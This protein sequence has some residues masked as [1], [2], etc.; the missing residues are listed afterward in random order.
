[1]WNYV[2]VTLERPSA[3][4]TSF[5]HVWR[6]TGPQAPG[7]LS[8][9]CG[10]DSGGGKSS[11]Y[12]WHAQEIRVSQCSLS[13]KLVCVIVQVCEEEAEGE[14]ICDTKLHLSEFF[15][16][17]GRE[18]QY[19]L[20]SSEKSCWSLGYVSFCSSDPLGDRNYA[21][22]Q[23][24]FYDI[25]TEFLLKYREASIRTSHVFPGLLAKFHNLTGYYKSITIP[26]HPVVA[27]P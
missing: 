12:P 2:T 15:T 20:K 17:K 16:Y 7:Q 26:S 23:N 6:N 9:S 1:M 22:H 8:L 21:F 24:P 10:R 27:T 11:I 25:I 5:H 14:G 13:S 18:N 19:L 4:S 3:V